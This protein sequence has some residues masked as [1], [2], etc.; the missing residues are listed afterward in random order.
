MTDVH[1]DR[2]VPDASRPGRDQF[3]VSGAIWGPG[4][5]IA[6]WI[7]GGML[8]SR[9]SPIDQHISDLAAVDASTRWLMTLGFAAFALGVGVAA[10]P[11]RWLIGWPAALVLGINAALML[12]IA[13]TPTGGSPDTEFVHAMLALLLYASLAAVGPL[14]ALSMRRHGAIVALGSLA[15]GVVTLA[16]LSASLGETRSGLLQR[17][18]ITVT[19]AWLI[20]IGIAAV[21]GRLHRHGRAASLPEESLSRR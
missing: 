12:G 2:D 13:L 11:L 14:A 9:Y 16:F 4:I 6:A 18:G 1:G 21:T 20:A 7:I 17:I 19:D 5:F 3:L 10:W 8:L 15:V